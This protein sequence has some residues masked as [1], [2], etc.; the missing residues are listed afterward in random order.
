MFEA[1]GKYAVFSGR[2][3]RQEYWLFQLLVFCFNFICYF[4]TQI[5]NPEYVVVVI[6]INFAF[7]IPSIAVSAR[8]MHDLDKDGAWAIF[9]AIPVV[10]LGFMIAACF[11]G[12]AGVNQYGPDPKG[13]GNSLPGGHGDNGAQDT[14]SME[15]GLPVQGEHSLPGL[16]PTLSKDLL[17]AEAK[18]HLKQN[19]FDDFPYAADR[20]RL[21]VRHGYKL[22][23]QQIGDRSLRYAMIVDDEGV[24]NDYAAA[25]RWLRSAP[26]DAGYEAQCSLG[27]LYFYGLGVPQDYAE[28]FKWLRRPI[29][30]GH[31][32]VHAQF[33][34]GAMYHLG[35]GVEQDYFQ[36]VKWI[37]LAAEQGHADAQ[38]GLGAMYRLGQGV[39]QDYAEMGK[40]YQLAAEQGY[41]DIHA[42]FAL[43]VKYHL[44]QG[45]ERD[46]AKA[47]KWYRLAGEGGHAEAQNNLASIYKYGQG[48]EQD[49]AEAVKWYGLAA[50]QGH[51]EAQCSLGTMYFDGEGACPQDFVQ[52]AKFWRLAA[53]Q[54]H[55]EA[56]WRLGTMYDNGKGFPESAIEA[57]KWYRLA[58]EQGHAE[59]QFSLGTMYFD[60]SGIPESAVEAE[61]WLL[62]AVEQGHTEAQARLNEMYAPGEDIE[63][64]HVD[65]KPIEGGGS[66][67][68]S[69]SPDI[70]A[71]KAV[72]D[73]LKIYLKELK[74]LHEEGMIDDD[75][76]KSLKGRALDL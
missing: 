54:G 34:F 44:G 5:T 66:G 63:K 11:D 56:Q 6:L 43:G 22:A 20:L 73:D 4:I 26:L 13:R 57:G 67:L 48:T 1:L 3:G 53:G 55:A 41:T 60:G 19:A 64:D 65:P 62:L 36:A 15:Q 45:V 17:D 14:G 32:D 2:A 47:V 9:S 50:N 8:R 38:V 69:K 16:K 40:W 39:E 59:A 52:A 42:Q 75:E 12:T 31:T 33:A 24:P 72:D 30:R 76:Y 74:S 29:E 25:V 10:S 46:Y 21:A 68:Q 70:H 71:S 28:A 7:F 35:Q 18:S 49:Y 61:K 58:A 51:A 27:L 23:Q 37:R